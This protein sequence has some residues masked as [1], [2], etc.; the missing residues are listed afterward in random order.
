[1]ITYEDNYF[2]IKVD[3]PSD[4]RMTSWSSRKTMP[5]S[6]IRNQLTLD[7]LPKENGDYIFLMSALRSIEER[8]SIMLAPRFYIMVHRRTDGFNLFNETKQMSDL[9]EYEDTFLQILGHEAQGIKI[10][11]SNGDYNLITKVLAWEET[12][13][14]WISACCTGDTLQNFMAAEEILNSIVRI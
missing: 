11:Q 12:P 10:V 7:D 2:G 6:P 13:E 8:P 9:I 3:L 14:L 5:E 1:M 4:W